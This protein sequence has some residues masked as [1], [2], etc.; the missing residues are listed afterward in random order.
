VRHLQ[1]QRAGRCWLI[2]PHIP[3]ADRQSICRRAGTAVRPPSYQC[4]CAGL[5]RDE[6]D[7]RLH[8]RRRFVYASRANSLA[9][10]IRLRRVAFGREAATGRKPTLHPASERGRPIAPYAAANCTMFQGRSASLKQR[11]ASV[12]LADRFKPRA[13]RC[14]HTST[15]SAAI[16]A[17]CGI[18]TLPYCRMRFLPSFC[19][20]SSLR[21]RVASPP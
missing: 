3:R 4:L 17:S 14:L 6:A 2:G 20:S 5:L 19:F 11:D 12:T 13:R 8:A 15:F 16:N 10:T 7:S 21:F 18:S 9:S 1:L